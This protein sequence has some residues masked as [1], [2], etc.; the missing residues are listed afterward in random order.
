MPPQTADLL[1]GGAWWAEERV[2]EFGELVQGSISTWLKALNLERYAAV[3]EQNGVDLQSLPLLRETDL[4]E[5]G[6]LLGHRRILLKAIGE[7]SSTLG[8]TTLASTA[9]H[10]AATGGAGERRQLTVMFCDLVGSTA[11]AERLDPEDLRVLLNNYRSRCGEVVTRYEGFVAR[12]VGDGILIYFGW[13]KAHEEDAERALRAALEMIQGVKSVPASA[14][15]SVRIGVATGPVVVGEKTDVGEQSNLA[16]GGTLNLAARLQGLAEPDQIVIAS[17]TRRLVGHAFDLSDLGDH[18]V[19]GLS[20]PVHAWGVIGLSEAASRFE[21]ATHGQVT[22]LVGREQEI[23]LLLDRW[24][25]AQ[26][27][28]GQVVLLS[29]EPGIGKSRVLNALREQWQDRDVETVRFQCSPYYVNSALWPSIDNFERALRFSRNESPDS[30]LN[31]LESLVVTQYGRP[32]ADVRFI[33]VMLSIPCEARY[34]AVVMAPQKHKDE[35]LRA[36]VDLTEAIARKRPTAV[37]FEDVHWA[38][39]TSLE[40]LDLLIDR[41]RTIPLLIVLTHRP[42]LRPKWGNQ[43]HVTGVNL[44]K[45][46]RAQSSAIVSAFTRN[47]TLPPELLKQILS[48][49]DGVPLYLEELTKAILESGELKDLGSHYDYAGSGRSVSVPATLRDSLTARLDRFPAAKEIAQVGA[50]IGREFSYELIAAVAGHRQARLDSALNELTKSGLAFRRGKPPEA[51]Y[52]FKHALVQDAAYDSLLKTQRRA[53]HAKIAQILDLQFPNTKDTEPETL[54]HHLTEAGETKTAIDYWKK[55]GELT[56][57]RLALNEAILHLS[58][59][60]DLIGT[61]PTSAQRDVSELNLRILLGRAF[62]ALKGWA[63]PE[64]WSTFHPA[65]ELA[66]SLGR[67]EALVP[68]YFG[69]WS[70]FLAQGRLARA[71][72][73]AD[74]MLSVAEARRELDLL[75]VGHRTACVTYF[76]LGDLHRSREHGESVLALHREDEHR[77]LADILNTDP[78]N[79]ARIFVA[80]ATWILGY[81]DRAVQLIDANDAQ[82]RRRGHPF[83]LGYALTFAGQIWDFRCEP[84]TLLARAEEAERLGRSHSLLFISEVLAQLKKGLAWLR[85]GRVA[86][87]VPRLRSAMEKWR[88]RGGEAWMPY[89]RAALAEGVALG[90]DLQGGLS[91]IEESLDQIARPGWEERCQLA[92]VLRL[93]GWMLLQRGDETNAEA[94]Y[95]ASLEWAR[96]QQAK[97]WELRTA[98]SI[99]RLWSTQGKRTHALELLKP[100]YD[101]FTEGFDTKDLIDAKVLLEKLS[102]ER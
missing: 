85:A 21:A 3:F 26:E 18:E 89:F 71:R 19:K 48:K 57:K 101:W 43:G 100:I 29:G 50:A 13:P 84:E 37:L 44:T 17:S 12:H 78:K 54:A 49:A 94:N 63:A 56:L 2:H 60:M 87:A 7:A 102:V 90:G 69:L 30:R 86:E 24:Q 73:W 39:P 25:Q 4:V 42:E 96:E 36:L 5:L 10:T 82:A 62:M 92:E 72:E 83:D 68:I 59:G 27:G 40:V 61:L 91:L 9:F 15:L 38:D 23:S 8:N 46:T 52:T 64:V 55:A 33:A 65:L 14:P 34:G 99:A 35:T 16:V 28:E 32:L 1:Q 79:A 58:K 67:D 75:I 74:E 77:H 98:T 97:S 6:V 76:W 45:L 81:P 53:L 70:N 47:K 51:N 93:K 66:K 88:A 20:E 31:K 95:R 11:L 22:P 41:V 80:F